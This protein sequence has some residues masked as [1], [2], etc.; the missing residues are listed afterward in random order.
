MNIL[1]VQNYP[2]SPPGQL[3]D[4]M[5]ARGATLH[6]VHPLAGEKL[7]AG[8]DP[9][10]GALILGGAQ[11]AADDAGNPYYAE[12]LPLLR[13]FHEAGKPLLGICLGSQLMARVFGKRVH[14]H[15]HVEFGFHPLSLTEAGRADPLFAGLPATP[16][17]MEFHEDTF[18]LPD[19]AV[20]LMTGE[21]C[22]NQAYRVGETAYA[23]QCHIE[24]TRDILDHWAVEPAS[25]AANGGADPVQR[26][27][28]EMEA[29][30]EASLGFADTVAVRWLE[31]A[32]RVRQ[33]DGLRKSA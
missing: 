32:A 6:E 15:S 18:E 33:R 25:L 28:R 31:L 12:L 13:G 23:F 9:F 22:R 1:V 8:H 30:L 19:E 26:L 24:V 4:S 16:H 21:G 17:L 14:R 29:H 11:S 5:L 2:G 20:L 10:D 7:P 27:Q 3:G